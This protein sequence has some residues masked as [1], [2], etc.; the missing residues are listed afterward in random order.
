MDTKQGRIGVSII[1]E[2]PGPA[3]RAEPCLALDTPQSRSRNEL[4]LT[5]VNSRGCALFLTEPRLAAQ[6]LRGQAIRVSAPAQAIHDSLLSLTPGLIELP[7]LL[8]PRG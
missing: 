4:E 7:L 3:P 1:V 5:L 8:A 2:H 6:R